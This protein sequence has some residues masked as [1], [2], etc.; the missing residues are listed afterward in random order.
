MAFDILTAAKAAKLIR[1]S[2]DTV[3]ALAA[4][5]ES[6]GLRVGRIWRFPQDAIE[7]FIRVRSAAPT[8]GSASG[9]GNSCPTV[10]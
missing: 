7:N 9:G 2:R 4:R 10:E 3:Y 6:P 1:V 5:G 8:S